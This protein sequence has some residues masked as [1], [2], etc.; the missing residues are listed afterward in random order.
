MDENFMMLV[1]VG[2]IGWGLKFFI[3]YKLAKFIERKISIRPLWNWEM[4]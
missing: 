4:F 2:G 1:A 3:F